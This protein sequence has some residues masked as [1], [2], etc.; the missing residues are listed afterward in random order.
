MNKFQINK[1]NIFFII[2]IYLLR[3]LLNNKLF[4][5]INLLYKINKF[6]FKI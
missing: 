6:I 2:N 3:L 5:N 1:I 4:N